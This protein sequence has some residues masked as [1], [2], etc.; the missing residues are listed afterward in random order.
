MS[1]RRSI[2]EQAARIDELRVMVAKQQAEID[3]LT[4]TV[5]VLRLLAK[6]MLRRPGIERR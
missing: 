3:Q 5:A 6:S 1:A 2:E 4:R